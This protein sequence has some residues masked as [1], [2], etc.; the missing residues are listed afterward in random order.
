MTLHCALSNPPPVVSLHTRSQ[1]GIRPALYG[2]LGRRGVDRAWQTILCTLGLQARPYGTTLWT[3][4]DDVAQP[5]EED[6]ENSDLGPFAN[7]DVESPAWS[8]QSQP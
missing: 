2:T 7:I 3:R 6:E 5:V 8:E 1:L 4:R